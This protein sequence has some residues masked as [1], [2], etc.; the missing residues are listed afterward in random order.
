[1]NALEVTQASAAWVP[2]AAVLL[3]ATASAAA[4]LDGG[5]AAR[6]E[7]RSLRSGLTV[8]WTETARLFRQRRRTTLAADVLLWRTGAAALLVLALLKATVV[9][10]GRWTVGDLSVG[11]VWFNAMDVAVWAAVWLAGWGPNSAH[12]LV[13]GYRFL[14][15]A[16][17]YELPLMF[18]LTA[19]AVGAGSLRVGDVVA[20]QHGLWFVVWMPVAFLVFCAGVAGF[21]VWGPFSSPLGVDLA[22]GVLTELSGVDRWLVLAGRWALLTAGAAFGV[23]LFWGGGAGPLLPPWLWVLVKTGLL[24]ATLVVVRRRLPTLRPTRVIR[25]AW[26]AVLPL[27]LL[28]LLVVSV[29]VGRG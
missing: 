14:A 11:V 7:G 4:S 21:S 22:G 3:L 28:Q 29:V 15:L 27:V 23:N 13:G 16:L 1:V 9:P 10:L 12:S 2:L 8:P 5:L 18:A 20:A 26:L 19:P 24:L 25:V 6:A 17:A